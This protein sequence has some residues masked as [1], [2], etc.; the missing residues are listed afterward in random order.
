[1]LIQ[2]TELIQGVVH[3]DVVTKKPIT[4]NGD[5]IQYIKEGADHYPIKGRYTTITL[6][7]GH[8]IYVAEEYNRI[9]KALKTQEI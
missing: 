6:L 8:K 4:I 9:C 7:D 3:P 2:L 1:M 5:C